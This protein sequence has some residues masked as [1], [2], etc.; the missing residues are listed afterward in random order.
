[1]NQTPQNGT[2][3]VQMANS[4]NN[5][6]SLLKPLQ[7][8]GENAGL[9]QP[10]QQLNPDNSQLRSGSLTPSAG[11]VSTDQSNRNYLPSEENLPSPTQQ[12]ALYAKLRQSME[13][14]NSSTPMTDEQANRKF[15]EI[16]RLQQLAQTNAESGG[17]VLPGQAANPTPTPGA[18]PGGIPAPG[19]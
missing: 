3:P 13:E 7:P 18:L 4:Q 15:Q 9:D 8:G 1:M 16:R 2:N 6:A 11:D 12:S 14:Y 5:G 19:E 17:N 10:L